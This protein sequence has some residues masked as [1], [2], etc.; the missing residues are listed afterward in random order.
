MSGVVC[1]DTEGAPS[2]TVVYDVGVTAGTDYTFQILARGA[3]GGVVGTAECFATSQANLVVLASC[4][5]L[6][7]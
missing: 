2:H 5:P 4:D 7:P 3:D 1:E 6:S